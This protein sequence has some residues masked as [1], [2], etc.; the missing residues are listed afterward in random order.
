MPAALRSLLPRRMRRMCVLVATAALLAVACLPAPSHGKVEW[1]VQQVQVLH[2]HGSRS[3]TV[4][5]NTTDICGATPCGE[6]NLEGEVMMRNVGKF[7]RGRYSTDEEVVETPFL[8]SPD[9]DLRVV[10]S[11]SADVHHTLQSAQLFLAEMFPTAD[12]LVPAIHTAP[13]SQDMMLYT[14]SQPWVSLYVTYAGAAQQARMSPVIDRYF[15]DWKVLRDLSVG[16]WS[17]GHCSD[18]ATRLSCVLTLFDIVT[19]KRSVGGLPSDFDDRYS[20]LHAIVAEWNRGIWHYDSSK[21]FCVQQGGR[22]QPFLQQVM[23]NI[24][25]FVAGRN[26][27]KVMHYS[28]LDISLAAVWGT[29]G[30][31]SDNAMQP[32]YGQTFVLELV[33]SLSSGEYGVRVLRGWPG[34]TP[35]TDFTFSWDSAWKLQCRRSD[36]TNYAAK[37]NLCPLEDFRRYVTWTAAKDPR[38]MCLLDAEASDVLNCPTPAAEQAVTVSLSESCL[39]YRAACPAD[40][41]APG[42]VLSASGH[43]CTCASD[44]CLAPRSCENNIDVPVT[45]HTVGIS[46]VA[47]I[48]ISIATFCAGA[49]VAVAVTLILMLLLRRGVRSAR[50]LE[51]CGKYLTPS[52]P[53]REGM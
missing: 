29:L 35:E 32:T 19:A 8:S 51:P 52:E 17:E 20:D 45:V 33:K 26:T 28:G 36:G 10:T 21:A 53:L 39:L 15:P 6:L 40:A 9:Y 50:N 31:S 38:G 16:L 47:T 7:L 18:Y 30:D 13:T 11:R 22:G 43:H 2:R 14:F 5:Y 23:T 25:D 46:K 49:L 1:A 3:A 34:Q 24:D 12:R 42:Y 48:G 4:H 44:L 37:G 41:C 27:H